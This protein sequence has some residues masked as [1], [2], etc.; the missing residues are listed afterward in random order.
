MS[1]KVYKIEE[2]NILERWGYKYIA[3]VAGNYYATTYYN[4]RAI[5]DLRECDGRVRDCHAV[6]TTDKGVNWDNTVLTR[7]IGEIIKILLREEGVEN[8]TGKSIAL[9]VP[10]CENVWN[11]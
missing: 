3:S 6:V 11:A 2:L 9:N 4:V 10:F 5:S 8:W 1:R 7:E